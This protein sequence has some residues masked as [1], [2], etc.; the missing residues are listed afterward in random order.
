MNNQDTGTN[1]YPK[2]TKPQ[3]KHS[4]KRSIGHRTD[5]KSQEC[6]RTKRQAPTDNP[7]KPKQNVKHSEHHSCGHGTDDKTQ[8]GRPARSQAPTDTL[9]TPNHNDKKFRLDDE[10]PKHNMKKSPGEGTTNDDEAEGKEQP[11]VAGARRGQNH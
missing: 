11:M 1:G 7:R 3:T 9:E 5:T 8:E 4:E 6:W 10:K 2:G